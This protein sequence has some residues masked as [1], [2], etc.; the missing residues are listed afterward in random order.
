MIDAILEKPLD[1]NV[2][3]NKIQIIEITPYKKP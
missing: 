1:H 2:I 3:K